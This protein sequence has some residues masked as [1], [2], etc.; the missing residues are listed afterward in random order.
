MLF[1]RNDDFGHAVRRFSE[2]DRHRNLLL[3]GRVYLDALLTGVSP[4][5]S[6]LNVS[7]SICMPLKIVLQWRVRAEMATASWISASVAPA[8]F[9]PCVSSQM[10]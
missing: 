2:N 8:C 1:Q 6:F 10:Q 4:P 5:R 7:K 9:A 3:R